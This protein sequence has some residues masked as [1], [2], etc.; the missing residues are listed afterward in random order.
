MGSPSLTSIIIEKKNNMFVQVMY[1]LKKRKEKYSQNIVGKWVPKIK[2]C[3]YYF[4]R[5]IGG[6][7]S[8]KLDLKSFPQFIE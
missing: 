7:K 2:I 1:F 8:V 5:S 6:K 3:Q 4:F